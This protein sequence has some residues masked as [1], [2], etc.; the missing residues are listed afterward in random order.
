MDLFRE[1]SSCLAVKF[2]TAV[3]LALS[4]RGQ[5]E[6][7]ATLTKS[8]ALL[9]LRACVSSKQSNVVSRKARAG[10]EYFVWL[11]PCL[12]LQQR[13]CKKRSQRR[14]QKRSSH[15]QY[16]SDLKQSPFG[17]LKLHKHRE[18]RAEVIRVGMWPALSGLPWIVVC[19]VLD[20]MFILAMPKQIYPR[21]SVCL[22]TTAC[23]LG[24]NLGSRTRKLLRQLR[25]KDLLLISYS[26]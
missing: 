11:P 6:G 16:L 2:F 22:D 10:G 5:A 17:T 21:H 13:D 24:S 23:S 3:T 9:P 18:S 25:K 15:W 4:Y 12:S 7:F 20:I 14:N 19:R 1:T 26:V 8:G